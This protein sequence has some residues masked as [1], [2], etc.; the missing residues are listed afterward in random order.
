MEGHGTNF[1]MTDNTQ[2][3]ISLP[4]HDVAAERAIL[5]SM[6][7]S[8]DACVNAVESL[9]GEEFYIDS[10]CHLF[11][12]FKHL[13]SIDK[14]L[15]IVT[16]KNYLDTKGLG[17]QTGGMEY[18]VELFNDT[19]STSNI[20]T[21]INIVIEKFTRRRLLEMSIETQRRVHDDTVET[22]DLLVSA[23]KQIFG[24]AG[25]KVTKKDITIQD[26]TQKMVKE[27]TARKENPVDITGISYGYI[28]TDRITGGL[29]PGELT[30][31]AAR[32]GIGKSTLAVNIV[33]KVAVAHNIPVMIFS[34]EMSK[35][36]L[37]Y[38]LLGCIG[39]VDTRRAQTGNIS[40]D[41]LD[42]IVESVAPKLYESPIYID[43][44]RD[45]NIIDIQSRMRIYKRRY[46]IQLVIIDYLQLIKRYE[47]KRS[48][49]E[50]VGDITKG[51]RE[52]AG[53]LDIPVIALSQLN[54]QTEL[55]SDKKP[56]LADLRE[57]GN[58]EQDADNVILLSMEPT[59]SPEYGLL[60]V[61]IAKNRHGPI[62]CHTLTFFKA[63]S[64]LENSI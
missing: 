63:Q 43:D 25:D 30:I 31:I 54:R 23:E 58:I 6:M 49:D 32:P 61:D 38:K 4:P 18:L 29:H 59:E 13:F 21:Y 50:E 36:S 46:D 24:I 62:G 35:N 2:G 33:N 11:M 5:A 7:L 64:R 16:V 42:T 40:N 37:L 45:V 60:N 44:D 39:C 17:E 8:G 51:V 55:R 34:L 26:A 9:S 10:H 27:I 3:Q 52:F 41:E 14:K 15:D 57:S 48:R 53:T 12:A 20:S 47:R 56:I 19:S 22:H 1:Q 28:N